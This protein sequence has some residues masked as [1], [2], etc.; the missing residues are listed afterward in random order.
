MLL[1]HTNYYARHLHVSDSVLMYICQ[2]GLILQLFTDV[3]H[4]VIL[5]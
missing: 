1:H 2:T 3:L 5:V 4:F